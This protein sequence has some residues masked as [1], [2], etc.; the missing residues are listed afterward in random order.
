MRSN[1]ALFARF[2]AMLLS[3]IMMGF[4]TAWVFRIGMGSD[5][6]STM[7][8]GLSSHLPVS[9]G[10]WSLLL[11]IGLLLAVV[12]TLLGHSLFSWCLKYLSPS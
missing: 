7:N 3:N 8:A 2:A 11:N 5:P 12:C 6:F 4:A 9:Y 10:T 1:Q